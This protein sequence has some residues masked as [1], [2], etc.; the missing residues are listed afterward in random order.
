VPPSCE[1]ARAAGW[2]TPSTSTPTWSAIRSA[3]REGVPR[4]VQHRRERA[5]DLVRRRCPRT[6]V[7]MGRGHLLGALQPVPRLRPGG[8]VVV[9][10]V[11]VVVASWSWRRGRG[12]GRG[13]AAGTRRAPRPR[14][15]RARSDRTR[16]TS[17]RTPQCRRP[18]SPAGRGPPP[19][20][21]RVNGRSTIS[22]P[23]SWR[24]SSSRTSSKVPCRCG[25]RRART[26]VSRVR[27]R[28]C[29]SRRTSTTSP[30]S[31]VVSR[32]PVIPPSR[33][34][35][36]PGRWSLVAGRR[37]SDRLRPRLLRTAAERAGCRSPRRN[38]SST[39][40]SGPWPT[41]SAVVRRGTWPH[42][43]PTSSATTSRSCRRSTASS[44]ARGPGRPCRP[45][46][47]L[48]PEPPRTPPTR[49]AAAAR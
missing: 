17:T 3:P 49:R 35:P 14:R 1:G 46:A 4:P 23:V 27:I 33:L 48:R 43:R 16:R 2:S 6:R 7:R 34:R 30:V 25:P 29:W 15:A 42:G 37:W 12:R 31:S 26:S 8:G 18:S 20:A 40:R 22:S 11:V 47:A 9:V 32:A 24:A 41:G 5:G 10:V 19:A 45:S 38:G 13:A 39:P 28:W 36:S 44:S 21:F